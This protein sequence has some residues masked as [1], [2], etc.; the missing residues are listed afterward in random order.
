[1]NRPTFSRS[2][3]L[4]LGANSIQSLLPSTLISRLDSLLESHRLEDAYNLVDQKRKK[5]EESFH[6]DEDEVEHLLTL[7]ISETKQLPGRGTT[8]CLP[9][10]WVSMLHRNSV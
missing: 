6:I 9:T 2:S 3:V 7:A 1:M 4:V 8:L 10:N 5:L